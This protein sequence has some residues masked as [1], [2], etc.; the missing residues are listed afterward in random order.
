MSKITTPKIGVKGFPLSILPTKEHLDKA[1]S[2]N[3]FC[4]PRKC[5]HFVAINSLLERI[6][7]GERHMVKLDAGHVKLNYRGWRYIADTPA[8]VK[9]SLMLF[10]LK[11][12]DE[13]YIREYKLRLRRTTRIIP[14]TREQ[15][16][17]I[18][19][20]RKNRVLAGGDERKR[21]YPN[22]RERVAGF[23]GVV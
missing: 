15:K 5:W 10:D 23:S 6:A 19:A 8:H 14:M 11:R 4:D 17:R 22:M 2:S 1:I 9:R 12:Y 7:P 3:G 20:N 21:R 13:V 16:V 18:N